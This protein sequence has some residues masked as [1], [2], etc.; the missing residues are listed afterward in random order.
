MKND[1]GDAAAKMVPVL[2]SIEDQPV[3]HTNV[4]VDVR[5]C[6]G[7]VSESDS[8]PSAGFFNRLI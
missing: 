1:C 5:F 7:A 4:F 3:E 8:I 6:S 2:K